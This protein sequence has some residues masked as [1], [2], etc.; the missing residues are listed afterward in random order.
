MTP[1]T[2]PTRASVPLALGTLLVIF[3]RDIS[4]PGLRHVI[5]L[6][7]LTAQKEEAQQKGEDDAA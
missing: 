5:A 1:A 3:H 7:G 4:F 6:I 2:T